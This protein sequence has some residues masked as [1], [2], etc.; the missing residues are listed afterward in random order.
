[1]IQ[2]PETP[3]LETEIRHARARVDKHG[4][5]V[6]PAEF[7]H[8]LEIHEGDSLTVELD[9]SELRL[10]TLRQAIRRAQS[11]VARHVPPGV[12]LVDELIAD[13]RAEAE[14]EDRGE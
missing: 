1:M 14:A 2:M 9:Q 8:A 6:I 3:R 4:R 13:R 12:S 5:I 7:R 10:I 11:I